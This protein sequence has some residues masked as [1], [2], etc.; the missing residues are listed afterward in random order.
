MAT[1]EKMYRSGLAE[2]NGK[3]HIFTGTI[4]S[5]GIARDIRRP[6]GMFPTIL[7]RGITSEL[8]ETVADHAWIHA[9]G[10]NLDGLLAGDELTFEAQVEIYKRGYRERKMNGS[11]NIQKGYRFSEV[12]IHGRKR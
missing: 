1:K 7:L 12:I 8:G 10:Y 4:E 9:E 3:R 11:G 2:Y 6:A 5:F